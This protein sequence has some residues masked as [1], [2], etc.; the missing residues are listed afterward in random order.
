MTTEKKKRGRPAK[1]K[2]QPKD[3]PEAIIER[4]HQIIRGQGEII[5]AVTRKNCELEGINQELDEALDF[6][7]YRDDDS[8]ILRDKYREIQF[9]LVQAENII[10][11]QNMA[12]AGCESEL[13]F[14]RDAA[15]RALSIKDGGPS[16]G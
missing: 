6:R 16:E 8:E 2:A 13:R 11:R 4:L 1:T 9:R 7:M 10:Q 12:L 3:T 15:A 14:W 5:D